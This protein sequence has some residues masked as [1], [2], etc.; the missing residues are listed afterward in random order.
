MHQQYVNGLIYSW[1]L[2]VKTWLLIACD[3]AFYAI[4]QLRASIFAIYLHAYPL[5]TGHMLNDILAC[6]D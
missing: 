2:S 6:E 3:T 5:F 1:V 4:I